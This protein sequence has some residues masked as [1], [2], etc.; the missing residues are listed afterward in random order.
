MLTGYQPV[1]ESDEVGVI[2]QWNTPESMLRGQGIKVA[3]TINCVLARHVLGMDANANGRIALMVKSRP[4][5]RHAQIPIPIPI[6]RQ[7]QIKQAKLV[8]Q[9]SAIARCRN[10]N[11]VV[12]G[13]AV[14]G[15]SLRIGLPRAVRKQ[16]FTIREIEITPSREVLCRS[17]QVFRVDPEIVIIKKGDIC[18]ACLR[19]AKIAG[20]NGCAFL[21]VKDLYPWIC[22]FCG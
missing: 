4:A 21:I 9:T 18:A 11:G 15:R 6:V 3:L 13:Q 1:K 7:G 10:Q 12:L 19:Y 8:M 16:H 17:F 2:F 5:A 14:S 22:K 20:R